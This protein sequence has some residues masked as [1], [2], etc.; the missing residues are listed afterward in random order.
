MGPTRR[1]TIP[2]AGAARTHSEL[3]PLF[4]CLL[5]RSSAQGPPSPEALLKDLLEASPGLLALS[6]LPLG[7]QA[8]RTP[9]CGR[10]TNGLL[11]EAAWASAGSRGR[12]PAKISGSWRVQPAMGEQ[13]LVQRGHLIIRSHSQGILEAVG[14]ESLADGIG[15]LVA[16]TNSS[17]QSEHLLALGAR[18]ASLAH[19]L[20]NRLTGVML[21]SCRM[22]MDDRAV[23]FGQLEAHLMEAAELCGRV[24]DSEGPGPG[25]PL[26]TCP[27]ASRL[28][29]CQVAA[30]ALERSK[31]TIRAGSAA[32]PPEV[33]NDLPARGQ[34]F[35]NRAL[36]ED[37]LV[38]LI[39]NA[40]EAAGSRGKVRV[41][42]TQ[43]RGLS[44]FWVQDNGRGLP[45]G[46]TEPGASNGGT[47]HGL[48]GVIECARRH[49]GE[50]IYSRKEGFTR[51]EL[52]CLDACHLEGSWQIHFDPL[53]GRLVRRAASRGPLT[54][55]TQ[56]LDYAIRWMDLL[57]P[58]VA[59]EVHA[60]RGSP[61]LGRLTRLVGGWGSQ[62]V[63]LVL[64]S[65]ALNEGPWA[66]AS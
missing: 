29:L 51:L 5:A 22:R 37:A 45:A 56:R 31:S 9:G 25:A 2:M 13:G 55:C 65:G 39:V 30:S 23:G 32:L 48:S 18:S 58:E 3:E 66:F 4:R 46:A 12:P 44:G 57:T 43:E 1:Q 47:G 49:G 60:W 35:A 10:L 36:L 6:Y 54:L 34:V 38:N 50:L 20:R 16:R 26:G 7:G 14:W 11:G 62:H 64:H 17:Q 63:K 53:G 15:A 59:G 27:A 33:I 21:E 28:D 52:V 61:G 19:D 41:G 40:A 24:L 8:W 42:L